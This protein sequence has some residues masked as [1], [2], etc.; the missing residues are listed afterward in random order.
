MKVTG[1][2]DKPPEAAPPVMVH[3]SLLKSTVLA[4][5]R[6]GGQAFLTET[7]GT[8][9]RAHTQR[10]KTQRHRHSAERDIGG[11]R[12]R[13]GEREGERG[14]GGKEGKRERERN[15]SETCGQTAAVQEQQHAPVDHVRRGVRPWGGLPHG[16]RAR[17]PV[18]L[19]PQVLEARLGAVA[20][21]L[22]GAIVLPAARDARR[23]G[24]A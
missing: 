11:R 19:H 22:Q 10:K 23:G 15:K 17:V 6:E 16:L 20:V 7:Q 1:C 5:T 9:A 3:V 2:W 21:D 13:E 18:V 24:H 12:G 4:P 8:H 14:G